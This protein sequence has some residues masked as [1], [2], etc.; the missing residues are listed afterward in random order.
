[1]GDG[2]Y[3][4][5]QEGQEGW[6]THNSFD[7]VGFVSHVRISMLRVAQVSLIKAHPWPPC[8]IPSHW[9]SPLEGITNLSL[10]LGLPVCGLGWAGMN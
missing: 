4:S 5:G 7:N 8:Y 9:F 10:S 3:L 6:N 2:C 1:M